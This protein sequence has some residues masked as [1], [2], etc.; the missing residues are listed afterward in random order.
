MHSFSELILRS[1]A[2][3]Q[4]TLDEIENKTLNE[5]ETNGATIHIKNL[6]MINLQ[7][8]FFF[9]G[10]FSYYEALLQERL[11]CKNGLEEAKKILKEN[12]ENL[13]HEKFIEL[14]YVVNVLKHGKG[15]SYNQL[16]EKENRKINVIIKE[17]EPEYYDEGSI[18]EISSLIEVNNE[19]IDESINLINEFSTVIQKYKP[20][21]IL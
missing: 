18:D 14:Q 12:G 10:V 7:K 4:N 5:L 13:L 11:E 16:I 2:F 9:I 20:E 6:Q 17:L 15:R 19:F 1:S 21:I 8:A 3:L